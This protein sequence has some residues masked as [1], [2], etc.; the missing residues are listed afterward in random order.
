MNRIIK[1]S[2]LVCCM[3][4]LNFQLNAQNLLSNGSFESG[5]TGWN[6][7]AG[8]GGAATYSLSTADKYDGVQAMQA[9]ITTTG[10]NAWDVQSL[11]PNWTATLGKTYTISLYAKS[12]VSGGQINIVQQN[13]SYSSNSLTLTTSW[14]L[15]QF[16]YVATEVNPQFKIQF[17]QKGTFLIDAISIVQAVAGSNNNLTISPSTVYQTVEGFGGSMYYYDSWIANNSNSDSIYRHL[18]QDLS[19]DWLRLNN[20][21]SYQTN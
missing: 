12:L 15:Y 14:A 5:F 20:G 1:F 6:N 21:Y 10:V 3:F 13:T 2:Q 11:G 17:P 7:L 19:L 18:F 8:G 4:A 9:S 16:S